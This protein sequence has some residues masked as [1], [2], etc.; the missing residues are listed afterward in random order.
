MAIGRFKFANGLLLFL[1]RSG[2]IEKD[3]LFT[4]P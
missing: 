4:W 1:V 2:L 3:A